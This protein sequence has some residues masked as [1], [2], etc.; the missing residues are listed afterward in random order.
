MI[1]KKEFVI[2]GKEHEI[3]ARQISQETGEIA[4]NNQV[5]ARYKELVDRLLKEYFDAQEIDETENIKE[6]FIFHG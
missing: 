4:K 6:A 3:L 5:V 1:I 2:T